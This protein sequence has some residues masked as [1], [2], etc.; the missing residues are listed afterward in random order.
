MSF[1]PVIA[2]QLFGTPRRIL[3]N[4]FRGGMISR[5]VVCPFKTRA[6]R[7]QKRGLERTTLNWWSSFLKYEALLLFQRWK[8]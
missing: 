3:G 5:T 7:I 1:Y 8:N 6:V 2:L 4:I